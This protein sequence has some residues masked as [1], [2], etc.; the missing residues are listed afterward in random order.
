MA[1]LKSGLFGRMALESE[2]GQPIVVRDTQSARRWLAWLARRLCRREARA[3]DRLDGLPGT[4][5]LLGWADREGVG[6]RR[7]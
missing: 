3:L 5:R 2:R 6:D 1:L 4:P 7:F